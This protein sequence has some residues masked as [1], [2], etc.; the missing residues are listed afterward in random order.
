[1]IQFWAMAMIPVVM[2]MVTQSSGHVW[3]TPSVLV[4][5]WHSLSLSGHSW[6]TIGASGLEVS[7]PSFKVKLTVL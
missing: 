4:V 2:V 5:H 6:K 3:V 7:L 1:M